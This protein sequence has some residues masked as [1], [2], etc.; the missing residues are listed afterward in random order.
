M[1][2]KNSGPEAYFGFGAAVFRSADPVAARASDHAEDHGQRNGT[3]QDVQK[4]GE[5]LDGAAG[6]A[7][8]VFVHVFVLPFF[9]VRRNRVSF[10]L[11][12]SG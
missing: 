11:V 8:G 3:G 6:G 5:G 7:G 10:S 1:T 4:S 12:R 9:F 2:S